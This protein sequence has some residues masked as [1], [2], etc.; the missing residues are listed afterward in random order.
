MNFADKTKE[1]YY[2]K[3]FEDGK[4]YQQ[5]EI[6]QLREE[7]KAINGGFWGRTAA[8]QQ[9]EINKLKERVKELEK[10]VTIQIDQLHRVKETMPL[11]HNLNVVSDSINELKQLLTKKD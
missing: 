3:G 9:T 1:K 7:N 4:R 5:K 2:D 11:C 8:R 6:E 10:V